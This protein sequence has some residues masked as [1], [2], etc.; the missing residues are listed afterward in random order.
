MAEL[1]QQTFETMQFFSIHIIKKLL[2]L[3]YFISYLKEFMSNFC[4]IAKFQAED[5]LTF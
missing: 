3:I 2:C 5:I 1:I 4:W